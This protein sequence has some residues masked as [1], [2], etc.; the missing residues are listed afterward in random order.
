ME[1]RGQFPCEAA[2]ALAWV[3]TDYSDGSWTTADPAG[4]LKDV[5]RV[6]DAMD[7][8]CNTKTASADHNVASTGNFTAWRA[9]KLAT[10]ADG[11]PV[12][13]DDTF[14]MHVAMNLK[15]AAAIQECYAS[16]GLAKDP[17]A[18][19]VAFLG[20]AGGMIGY[21]GTTPTINSV[22]PGGFSSGPS[23]HATVKG[24]L[25][26]VECAGDYYGAVQHFSLT[27]AGARFGSNSRNSNYG[28]VGNNQLYI[29]GTFGGA[30]NSTAGVDGSGVR[31][32]LRYAFVKLPTPPV[33]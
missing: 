21:V 22:A 11:T 12:M 28:G 27:S 17:T 10:Y 16:L 13:A 15:T 5:T 18:T 7:L 25:A 3:L 6:I 1:V 2:A 30:V 19:T 14:A 20:H 9:Y 32:E 8:K 29:C 33:T 26:S 4:W 23:S 24:G 31:A